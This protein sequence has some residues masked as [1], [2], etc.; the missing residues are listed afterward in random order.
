[1]MYVNLHLQGLGG[2][3]NNGYWS[4]TEYNTTNAFIF[5]FYY[6]FE[7]NYNKINTYSVRA[8]RAF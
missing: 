3:A 6:G 2:F 5:Y 7:Y 1:M 4:S 8:V